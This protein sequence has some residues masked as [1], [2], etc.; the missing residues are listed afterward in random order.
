MNHRGPLLHYRW[1]G[2]HPPMILDKLDNSS[3]Y[4]GLHPSFVRAFK[5]LQTFDP[6]MPDGRYEIAGPELAAIIQRYETSSPGEK[7]WEA[8]RLHGDIQYVA[9]G[10]ELIGHEQIGGLVT[11]TSYNGEKDVEFYDP[12]VGSASFLRLSAGNFAIF[13]PQ[14]AHQP[15]VATER[16]TDVLKVVIKFR[17]KH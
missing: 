17:L 4:R 13:F 7:K 12:P 5:W 16:P 15:G 1:N 6:A 10:E 2:S 9:S 3:L 8:H 11:R 14:D